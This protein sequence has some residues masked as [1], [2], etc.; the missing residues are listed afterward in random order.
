MYIHLIDAIQEHLPS[1]QQTFKVTVPNLNKKMTPILTCTNKPDR[2]A[3]LIYSLQERIKHLRSSRLDDRIL[4]QSGVEFCNFL[5]IL[6]YIYCV[7]ITFLYVLKTQ[8]RVAKMIQCAPDQLVNDI[9]NIYI[10]FN[11]DCRSICPCAVGSNVDDTGLE[12]FISAY[13]SKLRDLIES[14]RYDDREDFTVRC[15]NSS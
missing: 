2:S 15:Y 6:R 14:G 13:Q 5:N 3:I 1:R 10:I 4:G 11:L 7:N 8:V 12:N 9:L